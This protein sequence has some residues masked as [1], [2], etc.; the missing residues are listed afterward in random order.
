[1][2]QRSVVRALD[3]RADGVVASRLGLE[4][5]TPLL[6]LD[7]LRLAGDE[8]LALDTVWLPAEIA[9]P[10]LEVDFTR[11]ALYTE[12]AAR[13]GVRVTGG[14]ERV[15]AVVARPRPSGGSWTSG[16]RWRCSAWSGSASPATA[17]SSTAARWCAG[18]ATR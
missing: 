13:C 17:R 11:T 14:R 15:R 9:E 5:S 2:V 16:P 12:L 8:P 10:L 1:M 3:V 6:R 18:T 4:E 7:R